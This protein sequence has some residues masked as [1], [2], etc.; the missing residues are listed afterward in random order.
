M[1]VSLAE[2]ARQFHGKV[3][4]D[5]EL[6]INRVASLE[7]AGPGD[8]AYLSD[9]KY[10]AKL[11]KTAA[12]AVIVTEADASHFSGPALIV[13]DPHLCFARVAQFLNPFLKFSPGVHAT[14]VIESGAQVAATAWIGPHSVVEA[15]A[16]IGDDAFVGPGCFIGKGAELGARN[17]L[18][19]HVTIGERCVFGTDCVI[20]PGAVIGGDGFGFA[21]N[22]ERWQKVPQLGRVV[23]GNDVEVGAN[24]TIDRGALDDTV[25]GNGVKLDNLIQIAHNV[26]I[27][28]NTAIAACVGIAGSTIIGQRCTLGGQSGIVG[29]LEITD[30]VHVTAGS[31][32]TSSI[33]EA[34]VYSSSLKAMPVDK[35]R[36]NAAVLHR[37]EEM[38]QRLRKIEESLELRSKEHKN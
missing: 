31:L 32:V 1:A 4:G 21:R 8:I 33:R 26:Q 15:G 17:R 35:W 19:G 2:L 7:S 28:D 9:R 30:D 12:G 18:I 29:H 3:K 10:L 13:N 14:A 38:S 22:G 23:M 34:G 24:T 37:L 5:P 11:A 25:I 36:R 6:T 20:Y 16:K 27:G